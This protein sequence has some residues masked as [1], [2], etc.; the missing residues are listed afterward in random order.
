MTFDDVFN[1]CRARGVRLVVQS[2]QLRAQGHA[3]AVNEPLK[4]GLAKHKQRIVEMLGDGIWPDETL[5]DVIE[6]PVAVPNTI[7]AITACVERQR[8]KVASVA[9]SR[10]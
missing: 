9:I 6:I 2:G 4:R 3:G 7:E 1:V 10:A 5:P 8:L